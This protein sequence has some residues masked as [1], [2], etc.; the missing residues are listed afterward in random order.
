M[1]HFLTGTRTEESNEKSGSASISWQVLLVI[2]YAI[3]FLIHLMYCLLCRLVCIPVCFI[4]GCLAYRF[5]L[6]SNPDSRNESAVQTPPPR[7]V[8][9][10][11]LPG[12]GP[13]DHV[14]RWLEDPV[15]HQPHDPVPL[16]P[17]ELHAYRIYMIQRAQVY[18]Y[19]PLHVPIRQIQLGGFN[20]YESPLSWQLSSS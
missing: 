5:I 8:T 3:L 11:G 1:S 4:L 7:Q 13:T 12:C 17:E 2:L 20:P 18:G 9:D 14:V 10:R 16:V 6:S 15:R 19:N